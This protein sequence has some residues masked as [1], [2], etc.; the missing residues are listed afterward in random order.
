M[1]DQPENTGHT[2]PFTIDINTWDGSS[3]ATPLKADVVPDTGA[4]LLETQIEESFPVPEV[5]VI[6]A[7]IQ[8][9][10]NFLSEMQKEL[11]PV[12]KVPEPRRLSVRRQKPAQAPKYRSQALL[13]PAELYE[14]MC[15][16]IDETIEQG[17]HEGSITIQ[18]LQRYK[19]AL[20]TAHL[21]GQHSLQNRQPIDPQRITTG[22]IQDNWKISGLSIGA[23]TRSTYANLVGVIHT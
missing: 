5:A 7:G 10:F 8:L 20:I 2:P 12:E 11:N 19:T 14:R 1:T 22:Q 13:G 17:L 4:P 18:D 23:M 6:H 3:P 15:L 9:A 16:E 21:I